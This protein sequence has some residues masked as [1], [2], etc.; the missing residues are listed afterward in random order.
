MEITTERSTLI[1]IIRNTTFSIAH[2]ISKGLNSGNREE[3]IIALERGIHSLGKLL[4]VTRW[5][6]RNPVLHDIDTFNRVCQESILQLHSIVKRILK[7]GK[8][9]IEQRTRFPE[10]SIALE[11]LI[12][13]TY[14]LPHIEINIPNY[15]KII[16]LLEQRIWRYYYIHYKQIQCDQIDIYGGMLFIHNKETFSCW[17]TIQNPEIALL[18]N[19]IKWRIIKLTLFIPKEIKAEDKIIERIN[20]NLLNENEV[21]KEPIK[22]LIE[23][24]NIIAKNAHFNSLL[25]ECTIL[26]S[27]KI[28]PNLKSIIETN[29]VEKV[30]KIYYWGN[31]ICLEYRLNNQT[32]NFRITHIPPKSID[33]FNISF[34]LE[35]QIIVIAQAM[36]EQINLEYMKELNYYSEKNYTNIFINLYTGNISFISP[37]LPPSLLN[38]YSIEFTKNP[39][40]NHHLIFDDIHILTQ[41]AQIFTVAKIL[42]V[43]ANIQLVESDIMKSIAE[44]T[45]KF[46]QIRGKI[47]ISNICIQQ[48]QQNNNII[49]GFPFKIQESESRCLCFIISKTPEENLICVGFRNKLVN[50]C[51]CSKEVFNSSSSLTSVEKIMKFCQESYSKYYFIIYLDFFKEEFSNQFKLPF[52][53]ISVIHSKNKNLCYLVITKY[54]PFVISLEQSS[55]D[56]YFYIFV[57]LNGWIDH[58]IDKFKP[59]FGTSFSIDSKKFKFSFKK[60]NVEKDVQ[61][62]F[63]RVIQFIHLAMFLKKVFSKL[64]YFNEKTL[65]FDGYEIEFTS[66]LFD[67]IQFNIH[68]NEQYQYLS[69]FVHFEFTGIKETTIKILSLKEINQTLFVINT[70]VQYFD[71]VIKLIKSINRSCILLTISDLSSLTLFINPESHQISKETSTILFSFDTLITNNCVQFTYLTEDIHN[72]KGFPNDV[73]ITTLSLIPKR[74]PINEIEKYLKLILNLIHLLLIVEYVSPQSFSKDIEGRNHRFYFRADLFIKVPSILTLDII[75]NAELFQTPRVDIL[76]TYFNIRF[77][78][79]LN[80]G[81]L[82]HAKHLISFMSKKQML[83]S[84]LSYM[85]PLI[86]FCCSTLN[87]ENVQHIYDFTFEDK[88]SLYYISVFIYNNVHDLIAKHPFFELNLQYSQL[89]VLS[90]LENQ[91]NTPSVISFIDKFKE[92][93]IATFR[94]LTNLLQ[95]TFEK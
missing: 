42:F 8:K 14:P 24:L 18:S 44:H 66:S 19:E 34:S 80:S 9:G 26:T 57:D 55:D 90:L 86:S 69:S 33:F 62:L 17:I 59:S 40:E 78:D 49:C 30:L 95:D 76:T 38:N 27:K 70:F 31:T 85:E 53:S 81:D 63:I 67:T 88:N 93:N 5:L 47:Q 72:R 56:L 36:A 48:Q 75:T 29:G 41:Y 91:K 83:L 74:F 3:I 84:H 52:C 82:I 6:G 45:D 10:I 61:L 7:N 94:H 37:Y 35:K 60:D 22:I 20:N 12:K 39:L 16:H 11:V 50:Y 71:I 23:Q 1:D 87:K 65:F 15:K 92:K 79:P 4:V 32:N 58:F 46:D 21:G 25:N 51:S 68:F 13:K 43:N 73:M 64:K 89:K 77:S 28:F 54:S 2:E